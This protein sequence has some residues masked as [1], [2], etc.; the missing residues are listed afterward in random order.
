MTTR[1]VKTSIVFTSLVLRGRRQNTITGVNKQQL[2]RET[3]RV[4]KKGGTFAIHDLMDKSRYGD[5]EI[6]IK[7]LL[8]EGYEE[9]CLIPTADGTFMTKAEAS[10]MFLAGSTLLVGIK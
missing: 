5:M 8:E 7:E 10:T 4:L 6:F 9:V 3:L 1:D 2:L